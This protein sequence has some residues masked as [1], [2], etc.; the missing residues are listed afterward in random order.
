MEIS[1]ANDWNTQNASKNFGT[2]NVSV[3][4]LQPYWTGTRRRMQFSLTLIGIANCPQG[5][6]KIIPLAVTRD[7][8]TTSAVLLL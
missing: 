8:R 1:Q 5:C 4:R 2:H 6:G 3:I 7:R